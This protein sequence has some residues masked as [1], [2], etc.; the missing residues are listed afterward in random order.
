MSEAREGT[1]EGGR[2][3]FP[4]QGVGIC[5][6]YGIEVQ[7]EGV[8]PGKASGVDGIEFCHGTDEG[9]VIAVDGK[10]SV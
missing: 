7:R 10:G 5:G 2:V 4:D 9:V 8:F 3:A 1:G 6:A